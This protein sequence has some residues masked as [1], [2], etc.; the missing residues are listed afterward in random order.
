MYSPRFVYKFYKMTYM[1]QHMHRQTRVKNTTLLRWFLAVHEVCS[2]QNTVKT[3]YLIK[4][5]LRQT[6]CT[7]YSS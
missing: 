3:T 5:P 2:T 7:C 6:V 4:T 1:G